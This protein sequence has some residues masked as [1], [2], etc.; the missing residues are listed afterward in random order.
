MKCKRKN[1][2]SFLPRLRDLFSF[3]WKKVGDSSK[4]GT[5]IYMITRIWLTLFSAYIFLNGLFSSPSEVNG[6]YYDVA[7]LLTGWRGAMFGMWQRWDTIH[8]QAI[9]QWGYYRPILTAFFPGYPLLSHGV[10]SLLHISDLAGL[11]LVSNIFC[12]LS[13]VL[14]HRIVRSLYDQPTANAATIFLAIFPTSFFLFAGYPQSMVL[15]CILF[16]YWEAKQ[17]KWLWVA[18]SAFAAGI[19]HSTVVP[20]CIMLSWQVFEALRDTHFSLHW[21]IALIP[22]LPLS[23]I[24]L[25][26]GWRT[27]Q[28]FI[29]YVSLQKHFW[30]RVFWMPWNPFILGLN[31]LVTSMN[32]SK[33]MNYLICLLLII[34]VAWS[35]IKLPTQ[36]KIYSSA[37]FL[38]LFSTGST[39]DPLKSIIRFALL[40]FPVFIFL[41]VITKH[42]KKLRLG[43]VGA[44]FLFSCFL[45]LSFLAWQW[46]G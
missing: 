15:F 24:A 39:T 42:N 35:I 32:F 19:T 9:A 16:C 30:N 4:F 18:L 11:L 34:V 28:G 10:A 5:L 40:M 7:A 17:G 2:L 45:S 46:V 8:Y 36:L 27:S 3:F 26:L 29:P 21:T 43:L 37:L 25:F 31:E 1:W 23:G 20:L 6:L 33:F 12:W 13:F 41:A 44:C 14:L 22:F 38:F